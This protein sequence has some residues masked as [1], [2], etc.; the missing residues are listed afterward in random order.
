MESQPQNPEF[1]I[2]NSEIIMKTFTHDNAFATRP[3]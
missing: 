2:L 1:K 3:R